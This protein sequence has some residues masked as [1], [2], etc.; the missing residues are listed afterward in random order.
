[1]DQSYKSV[2]AV[3]TDDESITRATGATGATGV[4]DSALYVYEN[5]DS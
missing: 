2:L 1:M 4:A 5:G 3:P